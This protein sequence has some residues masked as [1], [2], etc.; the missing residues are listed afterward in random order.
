[1]VDCL[2]CN[3]VS[4]LSKAHMQRAECLQG[5]VRLL[6][7]IINSCTKCAYKLRYDDSGDNKQSTSLEEICMEVIE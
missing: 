5:T 1:M 2:D 3:Y 6:L 7:K 4:E